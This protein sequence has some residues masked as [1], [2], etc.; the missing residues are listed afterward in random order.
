[1][2]EYNDLLYFC[3][4]E[5]QKE[6]ISTIISE[7]GIRQAARKLNISSSTINDALKKLR[8]KAVIRGGIGLPQSGDLRQVA[9]GMILRGEST[10]TDMKTGE[11][12]L[13]W[14]KTS[15]DPAVT[16]EI[17][18]EML[19]ALKEDLPKYEATEHPK[20][21]SNKLLNLHTITDYHFG[22]LAWPEEVRDDAWNVD[23]AA[24]K[25]IT[26]IQESIK[27]SPTASK[28]ILAVLG[29]FFHFDGFEPITPRGKN[30]LDTDTRFP[31]LVRT[32]IQVLR[33][34]IDILLETYNELHVI[35]VEG[36]H[37]PITNIWLREFFPIVYENDDRIT[38]DKSP[39]PYYC[40]KH[41][42]VAL[43]WHHG[44]LTKMP[45]LAEVFASEF[46]EVFG[47]TAYS[48][49]HCG[50]LHHQ[51]VFENSLMPIEQHSTFAPRDSYA[52]RHGWN[53]QRVAKIS[54]YHEEHGLVHE[55][56]I[57]PEMLSD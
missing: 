11:Q 48:Y 40:Y 33:K 20:V 8:K 23:I 16:E 32:S 43:F 3:N 28:G 24:K 25:L 19:Q 6:Y 50:H 21:E 55:T 46:R 7:G 15:R 9:E 13:R 10:L 36:N 18:Q 29:D 34:V 45:R 41:G 4:T 38:F 26:L 27:H 30:Q 49:G 1:L 35:F 57:R 14:T 17:L 37:D 31:K 5:R 51:K 2:I 12:I 54:T 22:M 44:H 42:K 52:A 53:S 39:N 56:S 47:S